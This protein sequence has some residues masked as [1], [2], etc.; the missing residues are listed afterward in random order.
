MKKILSILSI[1]LLLTACNSQANTVSEDKLTSIVT[2]DFAVIDY[3]MEMGIEV[4]TLGAVKN[5]APDYQQ[6]FISNAQEIGNLKAPDLEK[7]MNLNPDIIFIGGRTIDFKDDLEQIAKV[8]HFELDNTNI[9]DSIKNNVLRLGE[10]FNLQEETKTRLDQLDQLIQSIEPVEDETALVLLYNEGQLSQFGKGSR[11]GF[12]FDLFGY[13][14]VADDI[15][16]SSHG[17]DV[18]YEYIKSVN[19]DKLFIINRNMIHGG[20]VGIDQFYNNPLLKDL[21]LNIIELDPNTI[22]QSAG[23]I[24]SFTKTI[25]EIIEKTK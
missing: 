10:I 13:Q 11:F 8:E 16:V 25:L 15:E 6:D 14:P 9:V 22:Y 3:L 23:G 19:P 18:S 5:S 20:N 17:V 4:D 1:V 7:V 24:T 21:D 2:Y 12:I